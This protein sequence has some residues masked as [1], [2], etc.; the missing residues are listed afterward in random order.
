MSAR[1]IAA[2]AALAIAFLA[3]A[4]ASAHGVRA[5]GKSSLSGRN[6]LR[7]PPRP[8]RPTATAA[9]AADYSSV[10]TDATLDCYPPG[11]GIVGGG[12]YN[13]SVSLAI[14]WHSPD[15]QPH[16]VRQYVWFEEYWN[17]VGPYWQSPD[18]GYSS[19]TPAYGP[20]H[21]TA[22]GT[23]EFMTSYRDPFSGGT[24]SIT[25]PWTRVKTYPKSVRVAVRA[26]VGLQY[27][28]GSTWGPITW[29]PARTRGAALGYKAG[30][31][32]L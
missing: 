11:G 21:M 29:W 27:L 10:W 32:A 23:S 17:N 31:C 25:N 9:A 4:S 28:N 20:F 6:P 5:P 12:P 2:F 18:S 7:T 1:R 26:M 22:S 13:N 19:T 24:T 3:P 16:T 30:F 15:G 8:S 14:N